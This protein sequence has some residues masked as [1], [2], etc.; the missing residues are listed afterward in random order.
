MHLPP[1][2]TL[3][4]AL[5]LTA[6]SGCDEQSASASP[7]D[8]APP[9]SA[10]A[11]SKP[12]PSA[13]ASASASADKGEFKVLAMV[14]TSDVK[15]KEPADTLKAAKPGQR[16]WAHLTVR[17][18]QSDTKQIVLAFKVNGAERS[19]MT[20]KVDPSWSFRT[21][22]YVTLRDTDSTGTVVAEVR[23]D[24]GNVMTSALLPIKVDG[25]QPQP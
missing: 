3:L 6:C 17:N 4:A 7:S 12:A 20:L 22:G 11:P 5:A 23:D 10:S 25:A 21:W 13:T 2:F 24:R 18:R 19:K 1:S 9:P 16:V 14:F 15:N 8:A